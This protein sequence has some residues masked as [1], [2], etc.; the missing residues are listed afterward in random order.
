MVKAIPDG[1]HTVTPYLSIDGGAAEAIEFYKRAFG[2]EERFRMPGPDGKLAHAEIQIGDSII[3]LSDADAQN[4]ASP[5]LLCLY[6]ED[7]DALHERALAAGA[8]E[9]RPLADQFY[10][11]RSSMV[12][13]PYGHKWGLM[14]HKEDVSPEEMDRRMKA[15]GR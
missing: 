13:D 15:M 6:V 7:C 9:L 11:D 3:M 2:A 1:F 5:S 4:P 14:T 10:G 12:A 8:R